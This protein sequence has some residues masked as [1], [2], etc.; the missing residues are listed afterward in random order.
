MLRGWGLEKLWFEFILI[1]VL[2]ISF[3]ILALI[4]SSDKSKD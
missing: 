3:F 4:S 2:A 1:F